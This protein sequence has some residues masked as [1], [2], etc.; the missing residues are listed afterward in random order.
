MLAV[1]YLITKSTS[2]DIRHR[3]KLVVLEHRNL[4]MGLVYYLK[5]TEQDGNTHISFKNQHHA[6][7]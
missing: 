7:V 2:S 4:A 5:E 3:F 6:N 1:R